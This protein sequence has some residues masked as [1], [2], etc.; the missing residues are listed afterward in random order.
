MTMGYMGPF[1]LDFASPLRIMVQC[2]NT[3]GVVSNPDAAPT[4]EIYEGDSESTTPLLN[5][6]LGGTNV[7]S[8]TGWRSG[9]FSVSSG[10]G[11]AAGRLYVLRIS[12]AVSTVQL[13]ETRTFQVI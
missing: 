4:W 7:N 13:V 9:T 5:G 1:P 2:R 10:N 8:R 6:A 12:Y 11:F 3:S